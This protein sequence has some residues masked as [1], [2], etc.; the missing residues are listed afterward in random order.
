MLPF[1]RQL[2]ERSLSKEAQAIIMSAWRK[3]T[4]TQYDG[5]IRKWT[6]YA[7][8]RG[9]SPVSPAL[10]DVIEFLTTLF[11]AGLG[12]SSLNTARS[13][14]STYI[15]CEG[16]SI[17]AHPFIKKFMKGV[18]QLRPA[19]PRNTVTWDT[20]IVINF[21]RTLSP[22]RRLDFKKLTFKFVTLLALLSGQRCQTLHAI[23]LEN[24]IL[25]ENMVKIKIDTL[26]KQSR[27]GHHLDEL[28]FK[29]YAPDRR[30]CIVTVLK[31]YLQRTRTVRNSDQLFISYASPHGA[32]SK[33]TISRWVKTTL[34]L[35]GIDTNL[36]KAHS[37]RAA[38]TSKA[39]FKN[40]PLSSIMQ[41]AG[42]SGTST[43]ARYYDKKC[44]DFKFA[45]AI[46]QGD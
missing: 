18:F 31:E 41:T 2:E 43:F 32:V 38:S 30:I 1:R 24:I 42:W 45:N 39:K 6:C 14:L 44:E 7:T 20:D 29:G 5:Y 11:H 28:R 12:Y 21:L 37:T 22:V 8:E 26:L 4:T 10:N 40:V 27:P 23:K 25:T 35:S 36:F 9:V 13:A 33:D 34:F 46:Q 15:C 19:L 3:S 17:G 16:V